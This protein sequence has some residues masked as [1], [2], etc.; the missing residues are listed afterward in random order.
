[1]RKFEYNFPRT[2]FVPGAGELTR[3][4]Q[5]DQITQEA[6][7][8]FSAAEKDDEMQYIVELLDCVQACETALREFDEETIRTAQL[9]V[10]GKNQV[11]GY[12][13]D[14]ALEEVLVSDDVDRPSH[15]TSGAHEAIEV[16]ESVIEGLPAREA[17]CLAS[18]LKYSLRAGLKDDFESDVAKASN[19]AHRLVRGCWRWQGFGNGLADTKVST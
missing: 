10:I 7:E 8:A 18:V 12:Y 5:A 4:G 1:M 15:Y 6:A 19:F 14:G 16:I 9:K 13:E 3:R 11:R 17:Y 2:R